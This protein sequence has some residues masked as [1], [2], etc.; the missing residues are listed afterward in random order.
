MNTYIY[1]ILYNGLPVYV[2]KT[3]QKIHRRLVTHWSDAKRGKTHTPFGRWL[4]KQ[5]V[6]PEIISLEEVLDVSEWQERERFWIKSL[7]KQGLKLFN[8]HPGGNG[9]HT[10]SHRF[11]AEAI[12]LLGKISDS[13]IAEMIGLTREAVRY[14]RTQL[15]VVA[16][17]DRS[18]IKPPA[19]RPKGYRHVKRVELPEE[20]VKLLGRIS[21]Q[22]IAE[23]FGLSRHIVKTRRNEMGI[24]RASA[25]HGSAHHSSKL[26]AEAILDIQANY[27][28][29]SA[30]HRSSNSLGHFARKYS[31][32]PTSVW[33]V[34]RS[35]LESKE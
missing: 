25:I 29:G 21:D 11:P 31:V 7:T 23:Q 32:H 13:R 4:E 26:S 17:D 8:T 22:K 19:P 9:S 14:H 27:I 20:A 34:V 6:K 2:G 24:P 18:R 33:T 28:K 5:T 1:A 15:G 12:E 35:Y 3:K 16:S 30:G 10:I